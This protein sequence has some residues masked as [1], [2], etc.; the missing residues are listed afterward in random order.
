M[1]KVVLES[2]DINP[3]AA[4]SEDLGCWVAARARGGV[5]LPRAEHMHVF[6]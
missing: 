2:Q 6:W 1:H 3:R 5:L 4:F